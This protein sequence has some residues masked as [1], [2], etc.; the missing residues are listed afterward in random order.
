MA[1]GPAISS[2]GQGVEDGSP[3]A[4]VLQ[5]GPAGLNRPVRIT[6]K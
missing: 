2:F 4:D 1:V 3:V 6:L 5:A